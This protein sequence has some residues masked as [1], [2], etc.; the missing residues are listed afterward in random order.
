[1]TKEDPEEGKEKNGRSVENGLARREGK[2]GRH[3]RSCTSLLHALSWERGKGR[4]E[5]GEHT[6]N[7]YTHLFFFRVLPFAL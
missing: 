4:G 5:E 2:G 7:A 6:Q 1:M 3:H